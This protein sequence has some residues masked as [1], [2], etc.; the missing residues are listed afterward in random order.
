[1]KRYRVYVS[2]SAVLALLF[3]GISESSGQSATPGTCYA[4]ITHFP[5]QIAT[6]DL[7]TAEVVQTPITP[8]LTPPLPGL[9]VNSKGNLYATNNSV[10]ASLYRIS[11]SG[12][13][14][15][16]DTL[17]DAGGNRFDIVGAIAF[18][19]NDV[20][21]ANGLYD[22]SFLPVFFSI[23]T[24]TALATVIGPNDN[25]YGGLAFDP[26][27]GTLFASAGGVES[28]DLIATIDKNSGLESPVGNTGF[29]GA[30][31]DIAFDSTG[32]L[33]GFKGGG[34]APVKPS[35]L[36]AIDKATGVGTLVD[37]VREAGV[38][39]SHL[40]G[41]T[42]YY[43]SGGGDE[44]PTTV[45]IDIRPQM[46]PN[47]LNTNAKNPVYVAILGTSDF[48]VTEID[49]GSLTF[50]GLTALD[51]Q[52]IDV[53]RPPTDDGPCA[54]TTEAGDGYVDLQLSFKNQVI[55]T[56]LGDFEDGDT[57]TLT[58]EG[59]LNDETPIEGEDCIV[60][61]K[62]N[63]KSDKRSEVDP[64]PD[65]YALEQN[66]PNPFNPTTSIGFVLPVES[67]VDVGVFNVMGQRVATLVSSTLAAGS[68]TVQWNATDDQGRRVASGLYI[69]RVAAGAFVRTRK[70]LL[71]E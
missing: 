40:S 23:D 20:L 2:T 13:A 70:M 45:Q 35:R 57:R 56:T 65:S 33:F 46:C 15:L 66:Y 58:L 34:A 39:L 41:L 5:R 63:D 3:A 24:A 1:M 42:C 27:D 71:L 62:P 14:T 19:D 28:P 54:C 67:Y 36:I 16:V 47:Q 64:G 51:Y 18:D 22:P 21:Y 48:D 37:T 25:A 44:E 26:T 32:H 31:P 12:V 30:T 59:E 11:P 4:T 10:G 68:H 17:H 49:V 55:L 53:S 61:Q 9:A 29:G 60:I 50:A 38:G 6:I 52:Y 43:P 7:T 8:T 69:Y